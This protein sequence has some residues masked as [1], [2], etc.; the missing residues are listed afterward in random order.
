MTTLDAETSKQSVLW[1][2]GFPFDKVLPAELSIWTLST[3]KSAELDPTENTCRGELMTL[4][5]LKVPEC[6][7]L[8]N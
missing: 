8:R 2:K 4:R 1:A 6:F 7:S 3:V 5:L